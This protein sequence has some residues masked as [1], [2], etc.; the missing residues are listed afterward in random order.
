[1]VSKKNPGFIDD[2][3]RCQVCTTNLTLYPKSFATCPHCQKV[4]CRRCWGDQFSKKPYPADS[5]A[6]QI[7][8]TN[9]ERSPLASSR[10][11]QVKWDWF[12]AG[13]AAILILLALGIL[14]FLWNIFLS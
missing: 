12:R 1:M 11:G 6:H 2:P 9:I 13:F 3:N 8:E 4:V 5:C 10:Q 7:E 14:F